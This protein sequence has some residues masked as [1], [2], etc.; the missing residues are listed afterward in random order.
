MKII[1][2]GQSDTGRGVNLTPGAVLIPPNLPL[3]GVNLTP[4]IGLFGI[5]SGV[6]LAL[7]LY[8][9]IPTPKNRG[10]IRARGIYGS[11]RWSPQDR[12]DSRESWPFTEWKKF[13]AAAVVAFTISNL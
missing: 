6:N 11:S 12:H 2:K 3:S 7:Y 10:R 1:I 13:R 4:R 9:A 8:L 5:F